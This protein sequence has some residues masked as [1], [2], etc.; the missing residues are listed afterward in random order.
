MLQASLVICYETT[1][2]TQQSVSKSMSIKLVKYIAF[3]YLND[4]IK[5]FFTVITISNLIPQKCCLY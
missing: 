3:I 2:Q 1:M 5:L 4:F